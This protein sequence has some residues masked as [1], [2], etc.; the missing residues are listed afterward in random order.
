MSETYTHSNT[1]SVRIRMHKHLI[2]QLSRRL[3]HNSIG[4]G[5]PARDSL[6]PHVT[7]GMRHDE[8][9]GVRQS[10]ILFKYLHI[11]DGHT[12]ATRVL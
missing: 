12:S 6:S 10:K 4:I 9:I 7:K 11:V 8:G 1:Y 2:K 5:P 3:R